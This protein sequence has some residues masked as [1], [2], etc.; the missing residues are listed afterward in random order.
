MAVDQVQQ[1]EQ[2]NPDNIDEVPVQSC[3]FNGRVVL[4]SVFAAP[5]HVGKE[6]EQA[7]ADNHVQGV[8]AGHRKVE[9]EIHFGVMRVG[10]LAF[11]L[12]ELLLTGKQFVIAEAGSGDVMLL[13]FFGVFVGLDAQKDE[14]Q[15]D[16]SDEPEDEGHALANLGGTNRQNHGQAGADEYHRVYRAEFNVQLLTGGTEVH[17][18]LVAVNQV[19]AEHAAEEHDFL[20]EEYP[21]AQAG[22]IFLLLLGREVVQ[23]RRVLVRVFVDGGWTS[24]QRGPPPSPAS[25]E[26]RP[27]RR[28]YRLPR[29]RPAPRRS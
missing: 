21:H 28:S 15:K 18:I 7:D 5:R 10:I 29:S 17:K 9:R 27:S 25:P 11:R 1:R 22:G 19:S 16:G 12:G 3:V 8:H 14:T 4:G 6:S 13:E 23:E 2:V 24:V 20:G 26:S